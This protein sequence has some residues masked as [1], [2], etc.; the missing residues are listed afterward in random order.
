MANEISE[1]NFVSQNS[2]KQ[3]QW[4]STT[5]S[6]TENSDMNDADGNPWDLKIPS[7]FFLQS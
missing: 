1:H 2:L 4:V 7:L 3:M 6:K 5:P